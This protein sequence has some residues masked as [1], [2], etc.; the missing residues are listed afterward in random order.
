[1][2]YKTG[3]QQGIQQGVVYE[4]IAS[5]FGGRE[6]VRVGLGSLVQAPRQGAEHAK[7]KCLLL[8]EDQSPTR[9][10]QSYILP[11]ASKEQ[12]VGVWKYVS[13][14]EQGQYRCP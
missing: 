6:G 10:S 3:I 1:M 7:Y 14:H 8:T 2:E 12:D 11:V 4:V 13:S 5:G 9:I